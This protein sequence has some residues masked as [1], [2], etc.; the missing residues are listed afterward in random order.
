M[1]HYFSTYFLTE[2]RLM[3]ALSEVSALPTDEL[4]ASGMKEYCER[5]QTLHGSPWLSPRPIGSAPA[6]WPLGG[7]ALSSLRSILAVLLIG[8]SSHTCASVSGGLTFPQAT[9][10]IAVCRPGMHETQKALLR[11]ELLKVEGRLWFAGRVE[12]LVLLA[13]HFSPGDLDHVLP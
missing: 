9:Q 8:G 4:K 2:L 11:L 1:G 3:A 12:S 10:R 6:L 5:L 13:G 7:Q